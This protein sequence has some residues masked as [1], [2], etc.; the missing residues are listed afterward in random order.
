MVSILSGTIFLSSTRSILGPLIFL[1][2]V[3]DLS[4]NLSSNPKLF[5][6]NTSLF[7]TVHDINQSGLNLTA[8]SQV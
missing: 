2:Y 7:L 5:A 1:I 6:G 3:D 8:H 4:G